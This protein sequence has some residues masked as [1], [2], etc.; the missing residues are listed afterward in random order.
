M[1]QGEKSA[2][3]LFLVFFFL[4]LMPSISIFTNGK[5]KPTASRAPLKHLKVTVRQGKLGNSDHRRT[6][7]LLVHQW[8][9]AGLMSLLSNHTFDNL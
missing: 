1:G 8:F 9:C 6:P 4:I 2:V 5:L 7:V 3:F